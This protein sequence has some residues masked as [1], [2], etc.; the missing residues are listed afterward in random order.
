MHAANKRAIAGG[1][2][3]GLPERPSYTLQAQSVYP[4]APATVMTAIGTL[5]GDM[6]AGSIISSPLGIDVQQTPTV[7]AVNRIRIVTRQSAIRAFVP[8]LAGAY[9]RLHQAQK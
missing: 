7:L 1:P 5:P 4:V 9:D 2:I 8:D 3:K 6:R